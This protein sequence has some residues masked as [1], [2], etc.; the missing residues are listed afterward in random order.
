MADGEFEEEEFSTD[1]NGQTLR[2]VFAQLLPHWKWAA[3]FLAAVA[4]VSWFDA[5]FTFLH[6][7]IVDEGIM[8]HNQPALVSIVTQYGLLTLVQAVAVLLQLALK[9]V[10]AVGLMLRQ[11]I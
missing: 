2:R 1:F 3:G 10:V 4:M 8:A 7:R 6:K 9:V 11:M 5:Y